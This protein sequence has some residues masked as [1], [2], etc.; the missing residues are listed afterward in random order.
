MWSKVAAHTATA[1]CKALWTRSTAALRLPVRG[2]YHMR[3]RTKSA[4]Y[5]ALLIIPTVVV[6][7]PL[8]F[9]DN[10]GPY[11]AWRNDPTYIYLL[12]SLEITCGHTPYY[13]DHPGTP[14]ELL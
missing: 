10:L 3:I 1:P 11:Y 6:V 9:K 14:L 2:D 8:A 4:W 7:V 12:N 13:F 5:W